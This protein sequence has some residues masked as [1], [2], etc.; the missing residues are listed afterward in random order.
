MSYTA[1]PLEVRFMPHSIL[2]AGLT[3]ELT[4]WLRQRLPGASF[5]AVSTGDETLNEVART[6]WS[7]LILDHSLTKPGGVQVLRE[8]RGGLKHGSLPVIYCLEKGV[9]SDIRAELIGPLAVH[10]LLY[11]PI[12]REELARQIITTLSLVKLPGGDKDD[13]SHQ[14]QAWVGGI[15]ERFKETIFTRVTILEHATTALLA[16]ALDK[17]L[18]HRA[19]Q[20]AHKLAGSVGTFGFAEGS[21]LAQEIERIL[22]AE[23]P[24]GQDQAPN[25]AQLVHSLRREL[26]Q[27]PVGSPASGPMP[28]DK[29]PIL[30]IVDDDAELAECLAVEATNQGFQAKIAGNLAA[31]RELIATARPDVVLLDLTFPGESEDGLDLLAE[32]NAMEPPVPTLVLTVRNS[33]MDRVEVARLGGRGFIEKTMPPAQ[34]I[35]VVTQVLNR[36]RAPKSKVMA[37]D[38]DP[39]VLAIL[40]ALLEPQGLR[41]STLEDPRKFWECLEEL[42]PDLLILDVEM[43]NLSGIE[44]CRVIRNEPRWA[45]LP[46]LF[47]TAHTDADT[48]S[49]I[50]AAGADDYVTKPV[51]GPELIAR[52]L[53]RLHRNMLLRNMA[54]IDHLTGAA[55][56]RQLVRVLSQF[57]SLAS[58]HHQPLCVAI[59]D[60]DHFKEVNDKFG[61]IV[62]DQVL[63]RLAEFLQRWF[64]GEDVVARWG[65]EE[66]MLGMYAMNKHD[67]VRRLTAALEAFR[68][69]RF[70]GPNGEQFQVTFSAGVAQYPEDGTDLETLSRVA[71]AAL[72]QAKEAGRDCVLPS[73]GPTADVE[74]ALNYDVV[75]VD[76]DETIAGL[77]GPTLE[78]EG[79]RYRWIKDGWAAVESLRGPSPAVRPRL[80][81]L[82]VGL[83]GFDGLSVLRRLASHGVLKQTRVI[84]LTRKSAAAEVTTA[85]KL[86]AIDFIAKPFSLPT[87]M[88]RIRSALES[89]S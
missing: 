34:V 25:L 26:E 18:Q 75:L 73:R 66:F 84:M 74:V 3:D 36:V 83:P 59:L 82:D 85:I 81:L 46:V 28:A 55:N 33:F 20:E 8:I 72:Y 63:R 24:L 58:R 69:E 16:G 87:L 76:D 11:Y 44:L 61:H 37:V 45:E 21:R 65:G 14:V 7:L 52:I 31:A 38:D 49:Q 56:R 53:N 23:T 13:R 12:D 67:G 50:F 2:V 41:L 80:V 64:R 79:Y 6:N 70:T 68:Q 77:L 43:P 78:A 39:Q 17:E 62:G 10:R 89:E 40:S 32:L 60:L 42:T 29:H 47:L 4:T 54:D 86:G 9:S 1:R 22:Q 5:E 88:A 15:W 30:L 19:M 57:F 48:V 35:E 51:V 27:D 71:D